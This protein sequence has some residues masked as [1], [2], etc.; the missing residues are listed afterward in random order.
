MIRLVLLRLLE[1][2]FRHR[3]LYLIPIVLMI[4]VGALSFSNATP[5]YIA[6][7][8]LYVQEES[9][10]AS[11]TSVREDGF[12]WVT[13]AKATVDEFKEFLETDAFVQSI[14]EQTDLK[15]KW[16]KGEDVDD[17]IDEMREAVWAQTVGDNLVEVASAHEDQQ[18]TKQAVEATIN[19]YIRWKVNADVE[20]SSAT[21]AFFAR[22]D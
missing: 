20:E 2:Y 4:G 16:N 8:K 11:F 6:S 1:S 18:V 3:W 10:L 15:E 7:S 17:V 19:S 22:T 21:Q 14:V 5:V 13:P 9:L 12:S